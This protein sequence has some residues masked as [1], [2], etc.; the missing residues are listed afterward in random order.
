MQE[1]DQRNLLQ[2]SSQAEKA[3]E[4][5]RPNEAGTFYISGVVRIH[6]PNSKETILET[7]S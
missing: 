6:D 5:K 2:E 1:K 4:L 3:A 7:R